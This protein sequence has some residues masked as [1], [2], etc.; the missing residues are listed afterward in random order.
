MRSAEWYRAQS[1]AAEVRYQYARYYRAPAPEPSRQ[2]LAQ[3]LYPAH[4]SVHQAA[5][6]KTPPRGSE[7]PTAASRIWPNLRKA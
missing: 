2:S 7:R 4:P 5:E 6:V 3:R 1:R